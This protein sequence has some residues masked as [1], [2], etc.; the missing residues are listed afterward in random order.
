MSC[1]VGGAV[2]FTMDCLNNSIVRAGTIGEGKGREG[3]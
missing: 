3:Q 2:L 1:D